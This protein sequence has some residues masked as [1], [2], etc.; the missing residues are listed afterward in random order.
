M[1][2]EKKKILTEGIYLCVSAV[3]DFRCNTQAFS[4]CG[5]WGRLLVLVHMLLMELASLVVE[6]GPKSTW[7]SVVV[8]HWLSC[9][10]AC[11]ISPDQGSNPPPL[12]WWVD[13]LPLDHQG[14]S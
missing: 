5:Q 2:L 14:R 9:S 7:P 6:Q 10:V 11:G 12:H 13:S 8:A 4:G 3:L 1:K